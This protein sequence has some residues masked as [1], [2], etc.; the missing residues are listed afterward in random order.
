MAWRNID[1]ELRGSHPEGATAS[2]SADME[3]GGLRR[4]RWAPEQRVSSAAQQVVETLRLIDGEARRA[5]R[6]VPTTEEREIVASTFWD[7]VREFE[8]VERLVGGAKRARCAATTRELLHPWLLRSDHWSR[9]YLKPHGYAGDFRTLEGIYDLERDACADPT[10][11]AVVN[12]L[13]AL[14]RSVHS[15][16]AVWHRRRW[17]TELVAE[18]LHSSPARQPVRIL[19]LACGGS[20]Y[21][22]DVIGNGVDVGPVELT[23][24]DR[25]PA[26]LSFI[27]SW[28]PIHLRGRTR[29]ICGPVGH[30]RRLVCDDP[31]EPFGRFDLVMSTGLFDY[32]DPVRARRLLSEMTQLTRPGGLVAISN[33]APEDASKIVKD[34]IV[35]WPVVY[36]RASALRD[37]VPE[38]HSVGF[39]RSPDGG[40]LHALVSVPSGKSA[41]FHARPSLDERCRSVIWPGE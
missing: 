21:V 35:S 28:L 29:L 9:S 23:F 7:A 20:R 38:G 12:L 33:F 8:A 14:Y 2:R 27:R 4:T 10:K 19:D 30:A 41:P 34:W 17:Y 5:E 6:T 18:L 24:L 36:R 11:P 37:L 13:D 25:D 3:V 26:A 1:T 32:L 31:T 40:L 16:R 39:D 15:V 22:R